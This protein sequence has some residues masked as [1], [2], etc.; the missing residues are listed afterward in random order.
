MTTAYIQKQPFGSSVPCSKCE[1]SSYISACSPCHTPC[2]FLENGCQ[3]FRSE[4]NHTGNLCLSCL[5]SLQKS[6]QLWNVS[7]MFN[8]T[9]K[10]QC[11]RLV[12]MKNCFGESLVGLCQNHHFSV[13]SHSTLI[14]SVP[15]S[16]LASA[17]CLLELE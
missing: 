15:S 6:Q 5:F 10:R 9:S 7:K 11:E 16:M 17:G 2:F 3:C 1:G 13:K 14:S 4:I 8:N 12:R